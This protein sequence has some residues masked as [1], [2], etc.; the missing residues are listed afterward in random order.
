M[1]SIEKEQVLW[2]ACKRFDEFFFF[3]FLNFFDD[4]IETKQAVG[5]FGWP[6]NGVNKA[7]V[8]I[9]DF[10]NSRAKSYA[11]FTTGRPNRREISNENDRYETTALYPFP[12]LFCLF[13]SYILSLSFSFFS[14]FFVSIFLRN[15]RR[16]TKKRRWL[17]GVIKRKMSIFFVSVFF[18][19]TEGEKQGS[20][21][22]SVCGMIKREMS[23][24]FVS[25]F[26]T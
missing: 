15:R 19:V 14:S 9:S 20:G 1:W 5:E 21:V 26:F 2:K 17:G 22:D 6:Q 23:I 8:K 4:F 12:F 24:F 25:I 13:S 7:P 3:I 16:K 11:R 18:Y 10:L